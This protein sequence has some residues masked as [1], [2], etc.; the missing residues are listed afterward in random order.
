MHDTKSFQQYQNKNELSS[1]FF[2]K[3]FPLRQLGEIDAFQNHCQTRSGDLDGLGITGHCRK[4]KGAGFEPFVPDGEAITVPVE[5][6][7]ERVW[8]LEKDE[9]MIAQRIG[10]EDIANDTEQPVEGFSHVDGCGAERD[11]GVG[12]DGQHGEARA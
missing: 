12:R 9:E 3:S 2:Q 7:H 4:T 5:H 11:V 6:F 8:A 1:H 10:F